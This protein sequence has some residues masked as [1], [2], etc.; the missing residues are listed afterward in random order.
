MH[1]LHPPS[2]RTKFG[3]PIIGG[4]LLGLVLGATVIVVGALASPSD[5]PGEPQ[6]LARTLVMEDGVRV[7][8][9]PDFHFFPAATEELPGRIAIAR[10][11]PAAPVSIAYWD[12]G[13]KP[14]KRLDGWEI[15]PGDDNEFARIGAELA[16]QPPDA[17]SSSEPQPGEIW[18]RPADPSSEPPTDPT[19]PP[20]DPKEDPGVPSSEAREVRAY[21]KTVTLPPRFVLKSAIIEFPVT[22]EGPSSDAPPDG[23]VIAVQVVDA[24]G[25]VRSQVAWDNL[26]RVLRQAVPLFIADEDAALMAEVLL[27]LDIDAGAA[28][29]GSD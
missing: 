11:N 20:Y 16:A 6:P 23:E 12:Y 10:G 15:A 24:S 5:A 27:Q 3:I 19:L 22:S 25:N 9:P 29:P 2:R 17:P 1:A 8:L 14:P 18:Q 7:T 28:V 21:G 13:V 26:G 4:A